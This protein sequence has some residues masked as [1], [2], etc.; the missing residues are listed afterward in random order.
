MA[1]RPTCGPSTR[2]R[3]R[4]PTGGRGIWNGLLLGVLLALAVYHTYLLAT[5][6][7]RSY[8]YYVLFLTGIAAYW[9]DGWGY[10]DAFVWPTSRVAPFHARFYGMVVAAL[11]YLQFARAFL[12]ASERAP[13]LDLALRAVAGLWIAGAACG[14]AGWWPTAFTVTAAAAAA[15]LASTFATAA[16]SYRSG[17]RP[18]LAYLVVTTQFVAVGSVYALGFLFAP[19]P[20]DRLLPVLQGSMLVEAL[21]LAIAL[22]ARAQARAPAR[23]APVSA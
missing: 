5:L 1:V 12:R 9:A 20:L 21:G 22:A 4:S 15:L 16:W 7:D 6:R 14:V 11:A 8:L 2:T 19:T 10:M 13:R 17:Y 23:R 3:S 18:A